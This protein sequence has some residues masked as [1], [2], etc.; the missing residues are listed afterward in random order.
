MKINR[1]LSASTLIEVIVAMALLIGVLSVTFIGFT[2]AGNYVVRGIAITDASK[3][4]TAIIEK[5]SAEADKGTVTIVPGLSSTGNQSVMINY[6]ST[7]SV[8]TGKYYTSSK[9]A[10]NVSVAKKIYY[11][12][13]VPND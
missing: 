5:A 3:E 2:I 4:A 1:N 10:E 7:T 6:G 9:D 11:T 13:F 12:I 8:V